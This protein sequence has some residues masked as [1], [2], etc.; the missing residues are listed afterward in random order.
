M[1]A[2][3]FLISG[4][5]SLFEFFLFFA[6]LC[7]HPEKENALNTHKKLQKGYTG[8]KRDKDVTVN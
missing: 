6:R 5:H 8:R 3:F 7:S 2:Q 4:K 1:L